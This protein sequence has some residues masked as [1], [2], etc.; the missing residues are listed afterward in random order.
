[1]SYDLSGSFSK[2]PWKARCV[3]PS[4]PALPNGLRWW[5]L[6]LMANRWP[7]HGEGLVSFLAKKRFWANAV[8]VGLSGVG[9][10]LL[11][12]LRAANMVR[13]QPEGVWNRAVAFGAAMLSHG[14]AALGREAHGFPRR[15]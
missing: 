2:S 3:G 11:L 13:M 10:L 6:A 14:G 9:E 12:V 15:A 5:L 4:P 7:A 8:I 1:M